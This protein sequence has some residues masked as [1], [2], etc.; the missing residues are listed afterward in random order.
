[1]ADDL[2]TPE[3]LNL[4]TIFAGYARDKD[5]TGVEYQKRGGM[6]CFRQSFA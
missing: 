5:S 4:L 2:N 3:A 1:M 6:I